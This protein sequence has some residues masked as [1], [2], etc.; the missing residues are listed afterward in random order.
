MTCTRVF[1]HFW[2][3]KRLC[4]IER[5]GINIFCKRY[6]LIIMACLIR[7]GRRTYVKNF[8]SRDNDTSI[9]DSVGESGVIGNARVE[10]R[11]DRKSVQLA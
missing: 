5:L 6:V 1:A 4:L 3:I 11:K 7:F 9:L 8:H 2:L 10:W